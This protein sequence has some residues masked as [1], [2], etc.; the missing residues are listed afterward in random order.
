MDDIDG[1]LEDTT[2]DFDIALRDITER[3]H[4]LRMPLRNRRVFDKMLRSHEF[5][6]SIIEGN[7]IIER[8]I[9]RTRHAQSKAMDDGE[10]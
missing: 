6:L 10:F 8:I 9:L 2:L 4:Y 5:R 1:F 7:D 3:G